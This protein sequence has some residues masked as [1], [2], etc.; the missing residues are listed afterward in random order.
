MPAKALL[1]KKLKRL[2]L[3]MENPP[4]SPAQWKN[5]MASLT[6]S[7]EEY[8]ERNRLLER[9]L[10]ISSDEMEG[11][12]QTAL[13]LTHKVEINNQ[14]L[15]SLIDQEKLPKILDNIKKQFQTLSTEEAFFLYLSPKPEGPETLVDPHDKVT[16]PNIPTERAPNDHPFG[17][18]FQM[19]SHQTGLWLDVPIGSQKMTLSILIVAET[20]KPIRRF[21]DRTFPFLF[22]LLDLATSVHEQRL[23][24]EQNKGQLF[25]KTKM[26]SLGE[27]AAGIAHEINNPL[28]ILEGYL[29]VLRT[30][31]DEPS[32]E[33]ADLHRQFDRMSL[34]I[35]R[36]SKIV[37]NLRKFSRETV[38]DPLEE[39]PVS[40]IIRETLDLCE[41]RLK[42][43]N[44]QVD[45]PQVPEDLMVKCHPTEVSQVLMNLIGNSIDAVQGKSI[46]DRKIRI[47]LQSLGEKCELSVIDSGDGI[48]AENRAKLFQPFFTTK[49]VG[50]GTGLGLSISKAI[51]QRNGGDL[52]YH[53]IS[54]GTCFK[55]RLGSLP[56]SA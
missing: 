31:I 56:E 36:I 2:G 7:F 21:V 25:A 47:D 40:L 52:E 48:T 30:Q 41:S 29:E 13:E 54:K 24:M 42:Y 34:T 35:Q 43:S 45:L 27:M 20:D 16:D 15:K 22:S 6:D 55:I 51:M 9:A 8:E 46:Q 38:N 26:T 53:P 23:E 14:V 4:Q 49:P 50:A 28:F 17:L 10:M 12:Y 18:P 44:I 37:N 11:R 5:L 39:V 1:V 3:S 33:P 19:S 32:I